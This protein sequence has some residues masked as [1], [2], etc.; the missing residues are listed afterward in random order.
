LLCI[1]A[2]GQYDFSVDVTEGCTPMKVKF[3]FATLHPDSVASYYWSFDNGETSTLPNPDT[4]IFDTRGIY[5]PTLVIMLTSGEER[6][7]DKPNLITVHRTVPAVFNY[8]V[9]TSSLLYYV[10]EHNA[11]LDTGLTYTFD[12]DIEEFGSRSGARQEITFPRV[13]TFTV[14]LTVSDDNGCTSTVTENITVLQEIIIPNVFTPGGDDIVNNYFIIESNGGIPLRIRIFSRAGV[15]VYE[16]EGPVIAWNGETAT[17]DKL[18]SGVYFYTLEAIAGDPNKL[19]T[20][21]GFLHLYR[22]D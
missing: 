13:D 22:K 21:A 10:F 11:T 5:S 4:V 7:I 12:W 6:W 19:Y 1:H 18:K 2:K 15:L 9:P 3:T 8:S 20:K 17:G 16:A 14:S